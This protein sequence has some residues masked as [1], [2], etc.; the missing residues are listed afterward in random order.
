MCAW[1]KGGGATS[2]ISGATPRRETSYCY[3]SAVRCNCYH[4][5]CVKVAKREFFVLQESR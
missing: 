5:S 1:T 2:I 3:A 4:P